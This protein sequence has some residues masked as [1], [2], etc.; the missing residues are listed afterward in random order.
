MLE[1]AILLG[2]FAVLV[3]QW[4]IYRVVA[5][6]PSVRN[7]FVASSTRKYQ[8]KPRVIARTEETEAEI[9]ERRAERTNETL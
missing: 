3:A 7:P 2:L 4:S 1:Y 5:R 8:S 9:E 6:P